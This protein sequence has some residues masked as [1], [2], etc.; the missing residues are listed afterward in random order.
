MKNELLRFNYETQ[1]VSAR[2]LY[3]AV[4]STERFS[5]WFE[6]QLQY[7]FRENEDYTGC[8]TFNTLARQ[9]LQ[10]YNLTID[11]AKEICMVQKNDR[12]REVRLY[13]INIEKAWN[14][15]EQIMARAL[16][17]ADETIMNLKLDISRMGEELIA[18]NNKIEEMKP[19]VSYLDEILNSKSTVV[20]T[21]I[22]KDYGMSAKEFN[23]ILH[24]LGIQY[25]VHDQWVLYSQYQGN[26]YTHSYTHKIENSS[27]RGV[28][29]NTQWTQKGRLFL[30]NILKEYGIVPV[31]EK[32]IA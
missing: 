31:I 24:E 13:L 18:M 27:Y 32:G 17:V 23:K 12:A 4:G 29:L 30:Y 1:T 20:V 19:K 5:T 15:P 10:D 14:T 16:K 3:E 7:G 28:K 9:E 25:K 6:R 26:G 22:A 8:K 11:M 2:D 21:Q